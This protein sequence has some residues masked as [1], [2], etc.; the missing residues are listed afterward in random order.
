MELAGF[1]VYLLYPDSADDSEHTLYIF[2]KAFSM[3]VQRSWDRGDRL[4]SYG[5]N[6]ELIW[7]Q[8][9]QGYILLSQYL[10]NRIMD[11]RQVWYLRK[12]LIQE[13]PA[14]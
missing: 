6:S 1:F 8:F 10:T 13:N 9:W 14:T 12:A 7:K 4:S 5:E 3:G 2:G 11:F